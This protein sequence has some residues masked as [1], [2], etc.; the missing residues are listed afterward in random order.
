MK[1]F[2]RGKGCVAQKSLL[3]KWKVSAM[4]KT[5]QLTMLG[6]WSGLRALEVRGL[7]EYG[8][9]LA[10]GDIWAGSVPGCMVR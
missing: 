3:G 7:I 1:L 6:C 9:R 10:L 8:R 2:G 4:R 5:C